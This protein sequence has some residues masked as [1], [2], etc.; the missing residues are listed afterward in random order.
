M[1]ILAAAQAVEVDVE[2]PRQDFGAAEVNPG[3][4]VLFCRCFATWLFARQDAFDALAQF[5]V[6]FIR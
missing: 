3:V 1:L 6:D 2:N 5:N 4:I